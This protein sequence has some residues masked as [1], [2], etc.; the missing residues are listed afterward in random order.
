MIQPDYGLLD[1]AQVLALSNLGL[2]RIPAGA[3][4][5]PLAPSAYADTLTCLP[6]K[7]VDTRLQYTPIL[8]SHWFAAIRERNPLRA[9]VS[10]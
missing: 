2:H 8:V 5:L 6:I 1:F 10:F 4:T 7:R 3:T 9:F